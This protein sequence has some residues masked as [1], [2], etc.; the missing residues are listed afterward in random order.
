MAHFNWNVSFVATH[1]VSRDTCTVCALLLHCRLFPEA[2]GGSQ[3]SLRVNMMDVN[4]HVSPHDPHSLLFWVTGL[5]QWI[6][7]KGSS[8]EGCCVPGVT[9]NP[10]S[11]HLIKKINHA[12]HVAGVE[13]ANRGN[14]EK[15]EK[16]ITGTSASVS[17]R[18]GLNLQEE[19]GKYSVSNELLLCS[20][21]ATLW[22]VTQLLPVH[23]SV[24]S[25][26]AKLTRSSRVNS[27]HRLPT[28]DSPAV[29][30][31]GQPSHSFRPTYDKFWIYF[32]P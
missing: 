32:S 25:S 9:F 4:V 29:Q 20:H 31:L 11:L 19:G 26:C 16:G 17:G 30:L 10:I 28:S 2:L 3:V 6:Q 22:E 13:G 8:D 1:V 23:A 15:T 24:G 27:S 14:E 18:A 7:I 21:P 5:Y 12:S